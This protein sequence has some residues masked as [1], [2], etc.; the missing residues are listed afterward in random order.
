LADNREYLRQ[1]D[2]EDSELPDSDSSGGD[3]TSS[4]TSMV[5]SQ[6]GVDSRIERIMDKVR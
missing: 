4:M 5:E 2:E 1:Q 6:E 3:D